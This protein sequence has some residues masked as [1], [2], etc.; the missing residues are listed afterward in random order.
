MNQEGLE[1]WREGYKRRFDPDTDLGKVET[2]AIGYA[3][4]ECLSSGRHSCIRP[5]IVVDI[6]SDA[7]YCYCGNREAGDEVNHPDHYQAGKVEAMDVMVPL[8]GA[9]AVKGFCICNAFKY[10]WRHDRKGGTKDLEKAKW[11]LDKYLELI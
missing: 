7:I 8:F 5:D 9:D 2:W 10:I 3:M 1:I 6:A 11:Y 4:H